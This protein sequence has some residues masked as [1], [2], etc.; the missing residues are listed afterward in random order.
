MKLAAKM[1]TE[2]QEEEI[3]VTAD[4]YIEDSAIYIEE[5]LDMDGNSLDVNERQIDALAED[6]WKQLKN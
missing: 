3:K 2:D 1:P 6:L 5:V 4:F